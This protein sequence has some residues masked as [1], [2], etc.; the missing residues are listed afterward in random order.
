MRRRT[1]LLAGALFLVIGCGKDSTGVPQPDPK[2][3][4]APP[5][6]GMVA[7]VTHPDTTPSVRH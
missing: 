7:P 5:A 1:L 6:T 2:P 4:P 3:K